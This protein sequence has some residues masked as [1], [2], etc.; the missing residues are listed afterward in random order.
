M[1]NSISFAVLNFHNKICKVLG[2]R[3]QYTLEYDTPPLPFTKDMV[4]SFES[5]LWPLIDH[6]NNH[7]VRFQF[8]DPNIVLPELV[9]KG[10]TTDCTE[11]GY[12]AL[13]YDSANLDN[14]PKFDAYIPQQ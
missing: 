6:T 1:S 2:V 8:T 4:L 14:Y 12:Y 7:H 10:F 9:L 3:N 13:H 5:T 11:S